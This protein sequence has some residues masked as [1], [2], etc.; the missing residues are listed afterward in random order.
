MQHV[1]EQK[2]TIAAHGFLNLLLR[3]RRVLL[4]DCGF[5]QQRHPDNLLLRHDVFQTDA[6]KAYAAQVVHRSYV[7]RAPMKVQFQQVMPHLHAKM[8]TVS[9]VLET[10]VKDIRTIFQQNLSDLR[11]GLQPTL[12]SISDLQSR[13]T[14][15]Q[16]RIG[17]SLNLLAQSLQLVTEGTFETRLRLPTETPTDGSDGDGHAQRD[18]VSMLRQAVSDTHPLLAQSHTHSSGRP[19]L[20]QDPSCSTWIPDLPASESV[21]ASVSALASASTFVLDVN[22]TTVAILWRE[23]TVGVLGR[24]SI[25]TM[26]RRDLK[27]A[28]GQRKLYS[29]RKIVIDEVRRL[30]DMR[31][32]P[33]SAVIAAMD[34]YMG[35]HKLSMTK[36]QDLIKK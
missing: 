3:L 14:V 19:P 8:D 31:T 22:H 6:Y 25:E 27:K 36:L 13:Q 16:R 5:L 9:G 35:E 32:E 18:P 12:S 17:A 2:R 26:V 11:E 30:A 29:R 33:V 21:S 15:D 20:G 24:P 23:W 28:E 4:Q 1:P 7:I 10:G 34:R